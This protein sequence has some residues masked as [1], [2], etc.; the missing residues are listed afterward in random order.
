MSKKEETGKTKAAASFRS[1]AIRAASEAGVD[2]PVSM[3]DGSKQSIRVRSQWSSAFAQAKAKAMAEMPTQ[4][5]LRAMSK[6][7][8]DDMTAEMVLRGRAALIAA[9]S[10]DE[11]CNEENVLEFLRECPHI[12]EQ[13]DTF[14]GNSGNYSGR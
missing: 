2:V 3:P 7:A 8:R 12:A 9:W 14:A 11:E 10:F 5:E 4:D 1:L 6:V 13:I